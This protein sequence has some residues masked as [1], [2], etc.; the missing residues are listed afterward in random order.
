MKFEVRD[1]TK[2]EASME[3]ISGKFKEF[4]KD[5]RAYCNAYYYSLKLLR[6]IA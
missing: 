6:E 1:L 4:C 3:L 2:R 5:Y